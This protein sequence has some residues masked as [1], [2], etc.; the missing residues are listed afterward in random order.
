MYLLKAFLCQGWNS[1]HTMCE[2]S[3]W[4][5]DF[6][7]TQVTFI[8]A[9]ENKNYISPCFNPMCTCKIIIS[10]ISWNPYFYSN[11]IENFVTSFSFY[12]NPCIPSVSC[13]QSSNCLKEKKRCNN[14]SALKQESR[15][16]IVFAHILLGQPA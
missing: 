11:F 2:Q 16:V 15:H 6:I 9:Q 13:Q 12:A 3:P 14:K 1:L 7:W 10:P 5:Q 8:F 4:I